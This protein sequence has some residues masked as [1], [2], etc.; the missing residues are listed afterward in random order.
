MCTW[1]S[2]TENGSGRSVIQSEA[3]FPDGN[4]HSQDAHGHDL[5][6]APSSDMLRRS[7]G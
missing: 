3:P 5:P 1:T 6:D 2:P 7:E 4:E